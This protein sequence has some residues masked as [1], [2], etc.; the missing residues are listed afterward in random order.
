MTVIEDGR[1]R[2]EKY[3]H[4]RNRRERPVC[5]SGNLPVI[6][7]SDSTGVLPIR[8]KSFPRGEAGSPLGETDEAPAGQRETF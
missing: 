4:Q 3:T 5:R 6:S 7:L 2:F 8:Y 1:A